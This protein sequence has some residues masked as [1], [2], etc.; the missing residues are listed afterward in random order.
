MSDE[1]Q[2]F[3]VDTVI[4]RE[5]LQFGG[6]AIAAGIASRATA[7]PS[8][9]STDD[10]SSLP[11]F[12]VSRVSFS[13]AGAAMTISAL[14]EAL[15][16]QVGY[17]GARR[18]TLRSLRGEPPV[19][20]APNGLQGR[21]IDFL[22]DVPDFAVDATP[23]TLTLT[24]TGTGTR[25]IVFRYVDRL[26][27]RIEGRDMALRLEA[28]QLPLTT[29]VQA[30]T[31]DRVRWNAP[32]IGAMFRIER[33]AGVMDAHAEWNGSSS[34]SVSISLSGPH[35]SIDLQ[36]VEWRQTPPPAPLLGFRQFLDAMPP[37]PTR[38]AQAHKLASYIN[39][40]A[41][42]SPNDRFR[43]PAMQMSNNWMVGVWSWDHCFNAIALAGGL[44]DLAWDQLMLP[45]DA[46]AIDGQLPDR[47]QD[48]TIEWNFTKPPIHGWALD[49]MTRLHPVSPE[50]LRALYPLLAR[51]TEWWLQDQNRSAAGLPVYRHGNDSGWDNSTA[52]KVDMPLEA[53][54]LAAFLVI[55]MDM[56]A[57]IATQ[58]AD[59]AMADGWRVR[60]QALLDRLLAELWR[61]DRFVARSAS[62]GAVHRTSDS[63]VTMMPLVLGTRLPASVRDALIGA[64]SIEGRFLCPSGLASESLR[65][66][67]YEADG[68]WRG[69]VWAPTN[70]LLADA[71]HRLG[72]IRLASTIARRFCDTCV[73]SGFAENFDAT[74]GRPLRD[75]AYTWTSSVFMA[76]G[77]YL[78]GDG[79]DTLRR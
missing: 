41:L 60:S 51:N 70:F 52:F 19:S 66:P 11:H 71:L 67:E 13:T 53:P 24:G 72:Q 46:M 63:L 56:L 22:P 45:F 79:L 38:Y 31:R 69:P 25:R 29:I 32:T 18:L 15:W 61:G 57:Q 2:P 33:L 3:L 34:D 59:N 65:S 17:H 55:Q 68:Y 44:P 9:G 20:G 1:I 64:L 8:L 30:E 4:R 6:A 50:R 77:S 28:P 62:T 27:L 49:R 54:D 12:D 40:S 75:P 43:R 74:T 42:I 37:M 26:T 21:A 76:M 48:R 78:S 23:D 16:A 47:M 35:W 10:R 7:S 5:I 36:E 14:D 58:L 73:R 39:W